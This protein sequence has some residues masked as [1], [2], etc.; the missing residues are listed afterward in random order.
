MPLTRR[1]SYLAPLSMNDVLMGKT[2]KPNSPESYP[3]EDVEAVGSSE[4][5]GQL[6]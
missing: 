4:G 2:R 5:S 6:W 1:H 3:D